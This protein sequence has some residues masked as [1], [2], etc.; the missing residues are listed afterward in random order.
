ME[1][2]KN[3]TNLHDIIDLEV[4][5]KQRTGEIEGWQTMNEYDVSNREGRFQ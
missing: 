4:H 3:V 2:V 5:V 1:T